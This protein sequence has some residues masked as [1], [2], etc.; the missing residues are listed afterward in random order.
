MRFIP[1]Y[2]LKI[3][4]EAAFQEGI[5]Q[6][7]KALEA[8]KTSGYFPGFDGRKLYYEYFLAENSRA[9][10]VIV[11]GLSEFTKKFYELA[12]YLLNQGYNV[13]LYD[14]R[15]HGLSCRLTDRVDML[16]VDRFEDYVSD[17]SLF[18]S[19]VVTPAED[20]PIYLYG[21]SMGGA[22]AACYLTRQGETVRKAILS[23]PMFRPTTGTVWAPAARLGLGLLAAAQGP[24]TKFRL[25]QEFNP[26]H[27]FELAID[28]SRARFTH[29]MSMRRGEKRYQSTPMTVG[30]VRESL[31][32]G[33]RL[34]RRKRLARIRTP[35]LLLSAQKDTVVRVDA[36]HLFA[37]LCPTCQLVTLKDANHAMLSGKPEVLKQYLQQILD[38][39]GA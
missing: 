34:L 22:V 7:T 2:T 17:L 27:R 39:L 31:A 6:I 24:K 30:W 10:V 18:I 20:K 36:H 14:Q 13:F 19:Q 1:D 38:Y 28:Q 12:Y 5:G 32:I 4:E 23:A 11:H 15:C 35:I 37:R 29:N 3:L 16:H 8:C 9:S 25:S 26:D 21:H 33:P